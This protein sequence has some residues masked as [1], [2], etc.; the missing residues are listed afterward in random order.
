MARR[1]FQQREA[2]AGRHAFKQPPQRS[3]ILDPS[4]TPPRTNAS[5]AARLLITLLV[6]AAAAWLVR[7]QLPAPAL[8]AG[9]PP[10]THQ[11]E[12]APAGAAG[13]LPAFLPPEAAAVI[14][15]IHRGAPHPHRQDGSVF[16]NRE[17]HLPQ[18]PHGYYREY[19]VPTPG[20]SHRGARRIVTGGQ[21]PVRWYYTSD[22]YDSFRA[23][24]PP[25]MQA[26]Q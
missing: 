14:E 18:Q 21:P 13:A 24:Q 9:A 23:F 7:Q 16:G 15:R 2:G 20:L 26:P 1:G 6:L 22:H 4:M 25:P 5:R 11:Q 10:A 17:R 8:Q 12:A 3:R 19:T